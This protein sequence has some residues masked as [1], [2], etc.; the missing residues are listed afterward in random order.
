MRFPTKITSSCIWV[1]IPVDWVILYWYTCRADGRSPGR[2]TVTWLPNFFWMGRLLPFLTHGALLARFARELRYKFTLLPFD[3]S[4]GPYI[5]TKVLRPLVRYWRLQK[6]IRIVVYLDDR[7]GVCPTF[8]DCYSQSMAVKSDLSQAGFVANSVRS[9]WVPRQS[10]R[11]LGYQWDSKHN[12][13][14]I[15]VEKIDRLRAS[16]EKVLLQ[17]RLPASLCHRK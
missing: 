8:P 17:S 11:W 7:L 14:S 2:C 6:A 3:I 13:L 10:L 5:F 1:A 4:T 15:L 16:I 9:I 12:L